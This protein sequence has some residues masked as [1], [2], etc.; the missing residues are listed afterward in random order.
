MEIDGQPWF[1]GKDVTDILG[2]ENR[3]RDINRHVDAEDR[4]NYRNSTSEIN[5]RGITIINESGL[6]SLI[7]SSKLPKAK[8]F[9]HW[10]T[11]EV[12]PAI[13]KTGGYI[14]PGNETEFI[15]KTVTETL[16][17]LIPEIVAETLK[18][19]YVPLPD[20]AEQIEVSKTQY[21]R[22]N[23]YPT[24][25][26]TFPQ[27]IVSQVDMMLELM[28][29]QQALNFKKIERFCRANGYP[30]SSVSVKKYYDRNFIEE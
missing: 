7:L 9:K 19:V 17:K 8:K 18:H 12:L 15:I 3:S 16:L 29:E 28:F 25:L 20:K 27:E 30:I 6:Y 4:W 11:S 1:I 10:V 23:T 13:R 26:S 22:R 14:A 2:Y 21:P 24:K 5:N